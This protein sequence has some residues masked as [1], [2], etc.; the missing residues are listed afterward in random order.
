MLDMDQYDLP[1][2]AEE[3]FDELRA[4]LRPVLIFGAGCPPEEAREFMLRMRIPVLVTWGARDGIP[5]AIGAFGTHGVK[6]ANLAV[7]NADY[8]LCIGSRLDTKSTGAPASDFAP[9]AKLVMV[10]ID[11]HELLKMEKIGRPLYRAI[12]SD[13]REFLRHLL[14]ASP[15]AE[16][17][18][19]TE[20]WEQIR[21]WKR[22]HPP[23][24]GRPY[25]IMAELSKLLRPDD[26]VVS[27]TG[28]VVAWA[29][30]ALEM[31]LGC[32]FIHAWNMTP[33]GYGLPAAI[34]A[35][36]A[37]GKRVILLT[38]DGGLSVN[39]T[40]MATLAKHKLPV[41]ILLCNNRGH[42][43]CRQT[44]RVWLDGAYHG[45][46]DSDLATPNFLAIARAYGITDCLNMPAALFVEGPTFI[47]F[48]I[49]P[50]QGVSPQV[51]FGEQ[52]A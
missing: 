35:A 33:M 19:Q 24:P 48:E 9:R 49:E 1:Q 2:L 12:L 28:C 27:D 34:G 31:P 45:T 3:V 40:E 41:K 47:E 22:E 5:E 15:L 25:E 7:Q 13:A 14:R 17:N 8:I 4:A 37:T 10:D 44:Q 38:G 50:D 16:I 43:M 52:L 20:W 23:G 6:A 39:I 30:Q 36:F 21:E 11:Q 46:G 51:K 42:A 26:V 32:R 18:T 29:M